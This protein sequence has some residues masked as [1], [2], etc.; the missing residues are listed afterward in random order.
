MVKHCTNHY[1]TYHYSFKNHLRQFNCFSFHKYS[2]SD[3][4]TKTLC[5]KFYSGKK[6]SANAGIVGEEIILR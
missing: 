5:Q 2:F 6:N 1:Q 3:S 4:F